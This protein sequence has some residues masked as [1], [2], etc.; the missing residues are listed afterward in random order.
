M[1]KH[2][3]L[4]LCAK[5]RN[6]EITVEEISKLKELTDSEIDIALNS[7]NK[8]AIIELMTNRNFRTLSPEIKQQLINIVNDCNDAYGKV[9]HII[10]V[11]TNEIAIA[12]NQI[13][14]LVK[15]I[16]EA[17]GIVQSYKASLV[18][19]NFNAI[20]SGQVVELV[21]IL[22]QCEHED[23]L[24]VA[25]HAAIN[26]YIIR[27]GQVTRIVRL[28]SKAKDKEEALRIY[29][30]VFNV[31]KEIKI[32]DA[33]VEDKIKAIDFWQVFSEEGEEVICLL[34]NF[35]L[36]EEIPSQMIITNKNGRGSKAKN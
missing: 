24:E 36:H 11:A 3:L 32:S 18:A 33:L 15:V 4:D 22:S 26:P 16:S 5:L 35:Q 2:K 8:I 12:S 25:Y 20:A 17:K 23:Q 9:V 10:N 30:E 27:S 14:E 31:S 7:K 21:R 19:C 13:I 34:D 28:I 6:K 29:Y 1:T